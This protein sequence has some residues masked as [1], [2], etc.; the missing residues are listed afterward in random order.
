MKASHMSPSKKKKYEQIKISMKSIPSVTNT[1]FDMKRFMGSS[2]DKI[3][4]YT[5]HDDAIESTHLQQ[6]P[7]T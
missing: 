6:P 5:T 2:I 3:A 1:N 4:S 7:I